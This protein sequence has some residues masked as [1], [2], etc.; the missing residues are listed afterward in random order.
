MSL[1]FSSYMFWDYVY[2]QN[3]DGSYVFNQKTDD[4]ER[5]DKNI[6]ISSV[7]S[8][9]KQIYTNVITQ[10]RIGLKDPDCNIVLLDQ[11]LEKYSRDIYGE[12]RLQ[13]RID[14]CK[15]LT[16]AYKSH[17]SRFQDYG[18]KIDSVSPY[19]HREIAV[20]LYWLSMLK[21][22]SIEPSAD[23]MRQLG[24]AG[25]FHNEYISYLLLQSALQL[26]NR[27]LVIHCNP[28]LFCDFLYDLH[29]RSLSRSS[30]EF[31]LARYLESIPAGGAETKSA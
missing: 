6:Y 2:L 28:V 12:L 25:K 23:T 30:L 11:A 27:R 5:R 26:F 19:V 20:M 22:F 24:L 17:L 31:F 8:V 18:L 10:N 29:Y 13:A 14:N 1:E 21:P 7:L 3:P 4:L 16:S 9:L 15:Q